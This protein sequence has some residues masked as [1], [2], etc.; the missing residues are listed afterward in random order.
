MPQN[1]ICKTVNIVTL[2][3]SKNTVDSEQ[4]A[5]QIESNGLE[6]AFDSNEFSDIV[7]VNTCGFIHDAKQESIDAILQYAEAKKK[8]KIKKIIV[9]GCLSER[10]KEELKETI[11][12]ADVFFG[13]KNQK[14]IL[15]YLQ[16]DYNKNLIGER[17]LSTLNHYAY[18]KISAIIAYC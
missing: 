9:M 1:N 7:I 16:S 12:E 11:P 13:V 4:L 6:V 8:G 2:G 3:C 10:Y 5:A 18:L 14:E 17:K 15:N